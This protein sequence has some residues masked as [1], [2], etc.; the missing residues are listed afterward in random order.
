MARLNTTNPLVKHTPRR[1]NEE[2]KSSARDFGIFHDAP[3][4]REP[5]SNT[6]NTAKHNVPTKPQNQTRRQGT[7]SGGF[8]DIFSDNASAS[9]SETQQRSAGKQQ[10]Q[11]TLGLARVN[12]LLLPAKRRPRPALRRETQ[13]YDKENDLP[14][15][16][17]D[18]HRTPDLT[19]TRPSASQV[20]PGSRIG[21]LSVR[22]P[23]ID[24]Q[25]RQEEDEEEQEEQEQEDEQAQPQLSF[26]E[27]DSSDSLDGFIVS[28]NDELSSHETSDSETANTEDE[29]SP[30]PSPIRSP[31]KRLIRGRKPEPEPE[32][33][34]N[35][36]EEPSPAPS[37]IRSPRKRLMHG[38]KPLPEPESEPINDTEGKAP[39]E[40][41][42]LEVE[43]DRYIQKSQIVAPQ[44]DDC[45]PHLDY[46]SAIE[47]T[48]VVKAQLD[49]AYSPHS[50]IYNS[51]DLIRHLEDLDLDS[52][53]ES[54]PQP[55]T[56][57]S[58]PGS[59]DETPLQLHP[60]RS[61]PSPSTPLRRKPHF[62]L[63]R[64]TR[65]IDS[66]SGMETPTTIRAQKKAEAARKREIRAQIA[67]FNETKI[68]FAETFLQHLDST[69]DGQVTR[70]TEET[71]GIKIIW[72]KN[73]RNTAGRATVR[74][75]RI[76]P[77]PAGMEHAGRRVHYATIELSEKVLDSEDKILC[78]MTHEYCHLLDMLVT[79]NRGKGVAQH[80][81][82]FKQWGA[83]C[84]QA[85]EDHPIYGGRVEVS[86]KH[87]YE[88]NHK[89]VWA[90]EAQFCDFKV[91]RHSKSID[92][93]R[94]FCGL[95]RGSLR[96]IKPV[97][98]AVASRRVATKA[99]VEETSVVDLTI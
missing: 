15:H 61:K 83:K 56:E 9:E 64:S 31:R 14:D 46:S 55:K 77:G 49:S 12:S 37:P 48:N 39:I 79:N 10:K 40:A 51:N 95:C 63:T 24:Y 87:T 66:S 44:P 98:R 65:T 50:S 5:W 26:E 78:T 42:Q 85:L 43:L 1:A 90:C 89:Y 21:S 97:P 71:G 7:G 60:G 54:M 70:M 59:E 4:P 84:V 20:P 3:L 22:R 69:F 72:T 38:R 28:D 73:F 45:T 47:Q 25:P 82:S 93:R 62:S 76:F 29:L 6:R 92:P 8:F 88:I 94:Q 33:I 81:A 96:Q 32:P 80:G 17:S 91:G 35:A 57:R 34:H 30:V 27:E 53:N 41:V 19:P 36:E 18:G 52:D 13:D 75:E 11:K 86:T 67:R 74:S 2:A 58:S 68:S 16:A 23:E 99:M